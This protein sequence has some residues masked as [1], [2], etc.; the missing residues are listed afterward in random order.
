M[1]FLSLC[2]ETFK[3]C[4]LVSSDIVYQQ[5]LSCIKVTSNIIRL[6]KWKSM[7]DN[8]ICDVRESNPGQLLGRQLCSPLYQH[9]IDKHEQHFIQYCA[10]I[11]RCVPVR[12]LYTAHL[13]FRFHVIKLKQFGLIFHRYII[14]LHMS[15]RSGVP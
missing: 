3:Q 12:Y 7:K 14:I 4:F 15:N 8:K 1:S 13:T 10:T 2:H 5:L 11:Q 9:R 6:Q